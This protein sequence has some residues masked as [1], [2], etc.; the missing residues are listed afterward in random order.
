MKPALRFLILF[1]FSICLN[2]AMPKI[3]AEPLA[4]K[5]VVELALSHS[6]VSSGMAADE[7]RA[8]AS[9]H[10]AR[11]QYLPTLVVGSG[12]GATWCYQLSL[13]GSPS[14]IVIVTDNSAVLNPSV[15]D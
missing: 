5:H 9:Y 12:I 1:V 6:T 15:R 11:N 8:F 7:Q 13:V 3:L 10:G 2:P 4:L 14:S